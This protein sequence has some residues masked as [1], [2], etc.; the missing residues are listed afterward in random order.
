MGVGP[1][2]QGRSTT[3]RGWLAGFFSRKRPVR[4][5][6]ASTKYLI[7]K[8]VPQGALLF[9]LFFKNELIRL[10]VIRVINF[11]L[12]EE[13][14]VR[15][16]D[17]SSWANKRKYSIF[18]V[19]L[20]IACIPLYYIFYI[21][22]H[23]PQSCTDRKK[24]QNEIGIDCGGVCS[25]LCKEETSD[26]IVSWSRILKVDE[27][28]YTAVAYIENPNITAGAKDVPYVFRV[29][30]EEGVV[31]EEKKGVT[32]LYPK[33]AFAIVEPGVIT[34][35]RNAVRMT[36]EFT[37]SPVWK[38]QSENLIPLVIEDKIILKEDTSPRIEAYIRNTS[39][40]IVRNISVIAIAYDE[41]GNAVGASKTLVEKLGNREKKNLIFTWPHP[42]GSK[43]S[44]IEIVPSI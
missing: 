25:L 37:E 36:F 32:D 20:L 21:Q 44:K 19:F 30:G 16:E 6:A 33:N 11:S 15:I 39:P 17:M 43:V 7:F 41:K 13:L 35:E 4:S 23:K 12:S 5:I 34:G 10:R 38:R 14:F 31:I 18:L 26:V 22:T 40:Q 1:H 9:C 28:I 8:R 2:V 3:V 42:F 27:G 24:N 29:Y